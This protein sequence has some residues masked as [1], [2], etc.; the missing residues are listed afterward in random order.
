MK[1]GRIVFTFHPHPCEV[2]TGRP[3][4]LI[5]PYKRRVEMLLRMGFSPIVVEFS[6]ELAKMK[7]EEFLREMDYRF[8][9]RKY[10]VGDDFTLGADHQRAVGLPEWFE[11]LSPKEKEGRKISSTWVRNLLCEG[12]VEEARGLLGYWPR[13]WGTV[14][15]GDG[16]GRQI[17]FP[18]A[19]I[20]WEGDL[21]FRQGVYGVKVVV[22]KK[23]WKGVMSIGRRPTLKGKDLRVE[24]YILGFQGD[25]YNRELEILVMSFLRDQVRFPTVE[26]L[27]EAIRRDVER[28]EKS[29]LG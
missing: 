7:A 21:L 17:G 3:L 18:T 25:L 8:G 10:L 22:G 4:G 2:L 26:H 20:E 29:I 27:K 14:V 6:R 9:V 28:V 24:I 19:N 12:R 11:V 13:I 23:R 15:K 1:G 5:L 16:I